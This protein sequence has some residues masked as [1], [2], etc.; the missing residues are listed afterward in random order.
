[1]I[2][3]TNKELP[4]EPD[5]F[6]LSYI[7]GL[8]RHSTFDHEWQAQTEKDIRTM[9]EDELFTLEMMLLMNQLDNIFEVGNYS[10]TELKNRIR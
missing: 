10:A 5:I 2:I 1:M 4:D 3:A 8:I 9:T 6:R 7:E